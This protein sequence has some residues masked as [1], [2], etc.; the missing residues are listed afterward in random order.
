MAENKK[1][2]FKKLLKS[3][4]PGFIT[5]ASDDDPSGIGTYS[6]TGAQFG[7]SQLWTVFASVPFMIVVQEICGR[8]GLVTGKGLSRVI[9]ENYPKSV[10]FFCI[11]LLLIAN[12]INIGADLGAMAATGQLL[13]GLPFIFWLIIITVFTLVLEIFLS[14]R[15]YAGILK[16]LTLSLLVYI[17]ASFCLKLDC[18]KVALATI[19]PTISL[20]KDYI[21]N[22]VALLGTTIS[23]YLFFWQTDEE[24]EEEIEKHK[25][26]AM[27]KG[28]PK[29]TR[30]DI[31][32]MRM[33]T[34]IGMIFSQI[35]TFFI[36][37]TTASTLGANGLTNI[38]TAD[39]AAQALRPF[40]GDL[41]YILFAA[42][43]IGTG[44]LSVSVF[45]GCAFF[46][47]FRSLFWEKSIFKKKKKKEY[48]FL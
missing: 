5:G 18:G 40:A 30:K 23:Q 38:Q 32:N 6:Q 17:V 1:S 13:L 29:F 3:L 15:V 44:L 16:Y 21:I 48:F 46:C 22:I 7:I 28:I 11:S 19:T 24:V 27:G 42:G 26:R 14:Y 39:Q 36:I 12:T 34:A 33:D 10:L 20:S 2:G 37:V 43:V 9:K 45:V 25:I 35:I 31:K 47:I 4:G 41:S 8:I